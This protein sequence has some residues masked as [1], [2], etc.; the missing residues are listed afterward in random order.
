M[1]KSALLLVGDANQ[2][3][4]SEKKLERVVNR[5]SC[6]KVGYLWATTALG[7]GAPV[8]CGVAAV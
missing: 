6:A 5:S 2:W 3:T 4:A 8:F 7:Y 1:I